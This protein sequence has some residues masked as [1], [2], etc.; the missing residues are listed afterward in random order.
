MGKN[1]ALRSR[2]AHL[3]S[4]SIMRICDEVERLGISQDAPGLSNRDKLTLSRLEGPNASEN[5]VAASIY[6]MT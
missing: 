6:L 3:Y 5:D 1:Q 2:E 4:K